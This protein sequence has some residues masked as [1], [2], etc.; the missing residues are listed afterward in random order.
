MY[1]R[2][3]DNRVKDSRGVIFYNF[4]GWRLRVVSDEIGN[5][6]GLNCNFWGD[7]KDL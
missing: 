7:I 4:E 6:E 2:N 1:K 5:L 3:I